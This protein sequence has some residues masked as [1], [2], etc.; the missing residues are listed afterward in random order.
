L[1]AAEEEKIR[2]AIIDHVRALNPNVIVVVSFSAGTRRAVS[3]TVTVSVQGGTGSSAAAQS[4]VT[5]LGTSGS[6]LASAVTAAAPGAAI[7]NV[8]STGGTSPP[9]VAPTSTSHKVCKCTDYPV[10]PSPPVPPI[11][12][13][14]L[15]PPVPF[16]PP[17]PIC[18][19]DCFTY[20]THVCDTIETCGRNVT[21]MATG[22]DSNLVVD[23][24]S[25]TSCNTRSAGYNL[26][27]TCDISTL[28]K[29][30]VG[31][32]NAPG[33][34][35]TASSGSGS[36]TALYALLALLVIPIIVGVVILVIC[37]RRRKEKTAAAETQESKKGYG[38]G[39]L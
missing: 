27:Q 12:P 13:V 16:P 21:Y 37:L 8:A 3:S 20:K 34:P 28:L 7:S 4:V 19:V 10:P 35:G 31:T 24:Y 32:P 23:V 17:P 22:D 11:A 33:A 1:T 26:T 36:N 25:D 39:D 29:I 14:P 18:S 9:P 5:A 15:P 6:T 38:D 30:V 2:K